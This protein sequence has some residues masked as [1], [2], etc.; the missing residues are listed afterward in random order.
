M[1]SEAERVF[2]LTQKPSTKNAGALQ[3]DTIEALECLQS[4]SRAVYFTRQE[5][6]EMLEQQQEEDE[7]LLEQRRLE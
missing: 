2:L 5:L 6:Q 4:R 7:R 3:P 1:S